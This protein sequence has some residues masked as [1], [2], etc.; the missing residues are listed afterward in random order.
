MKNIHI[1]PTNKPSRLCIDNSCNELNYSEIEGLN[2]KH[3]TNQNIYIT[4][5]EEIKEG[6]WVYCRTENRVLISNVSYS[7]LDDRFKI[8]LTTDQ[9]LIKD[10]VQAIDDKFL[11]WFVKNPSCEKVEVKDLLSNNGNAFYGY[12]IIIPQEE[13]KQ[14]ELKF[15]NRQIGAA[16][17][18]ANQIMEN[19]INKPKLDT[20]G[21]E[22]YETAD[23]TITVIRSKEEIEQL[24]NK[25]SSLGQAAG[26]T[27]REYTLEN[28]AYRRGYE[29]C[30]EDMLE[31]LETEIKRAYQYGQTNAQMMEAG[32]ERDEVEEYVSFRMLS[33]KKKYYE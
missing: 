7:K 10:G 30:Q 15:K 23:M 20:V 12:K 14:E 17:F 11:E 13:P 4:S 9:D 32:L 22:F 6:D 31:F 29:Q 1:I 24:A 3:I 33:F 27:H 16:G 18:V 28:I 8:I 26:L 5:D 25:Y 2:S 19:M 21:K